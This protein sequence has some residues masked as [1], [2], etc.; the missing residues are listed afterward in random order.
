MYVKSFLPRVF[1]KAFAVPSLN[2]I[3]VD[4]VMQ[5]LIVLKW[6]NFNTEGYLIKLANLSQRLSLHTQDMCTHSGTSCLL[7]LLFSPLVYIS[8]GSRLVFQSVVFQLIFA[9]LNMFFREFA[10]LPDHN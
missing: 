10:D 4:S 2:N 7:F 5:C 1:F 3:S 6:T 9:T 8:Q